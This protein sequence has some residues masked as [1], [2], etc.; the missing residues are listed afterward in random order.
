MS[1]DCCPSPL[2]FGAKVSAIDPASEEGEC[3][4]SLVGNI[5]F[6]DVVFSYP[7]R[8]DVQVMLEAP[9]MIVCSI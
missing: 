9:G 1:D 3:P 2:L 6:S 5:E 8:P 7:A 4:E